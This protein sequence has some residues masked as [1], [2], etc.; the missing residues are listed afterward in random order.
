[1]F[2]SRAKEEE[3]HIKGGTF[4]M[5]KNSHYLQIT[6]GIPKETTNVL[7]EL[8]SKFNKVTVHKIKI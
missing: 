5:N 6:S 7:L 3:R 8:I 4:R 2:L 1:M